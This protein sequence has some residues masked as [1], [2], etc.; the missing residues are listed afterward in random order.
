MASPIHYRK[1]CET[2]ADRGYKAWNRI[3]RLLPKWR[4]KYNW[5]FSSWGHGGIGWKSTMYASCCSP[6]PQTLLGLVVGISHA[7]SSLVCNFVYGQYRSTLVLNEN[8]ATPSMQY[9]L[10]VT[11]HWTNWAWVGIRIWTLPGNTDHDRYI[12]QSKRLFPRKLI[13]FIIKSV[14][15]NWSCLI[16]GLR[17]EPGRLQSHDLRGLRL[18]RS[19]GRIQV[20]Y[21][22]KSAST[23]PKS[24]SS[25]H[26]LLRNPLMWRPGH[27]WSFCWL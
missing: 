16:G 9:Y 12:L 8:Y 7:R 13:I 18:W 11:P 17:L 4:G 2:Q 25:I 3:S 27:R 1:K 20:F 24:T 10:P 21:P 14:K 6:C 22:L 5:I 15:P 19:W 23:P 26:N